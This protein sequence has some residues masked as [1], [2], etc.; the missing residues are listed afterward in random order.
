MFYGIFVLPISGIVGHI[1]QHNLTYSLNNVVNHGHFGGL[2]L[3]Y[4]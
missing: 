1:V 3:F 4:A 2:C